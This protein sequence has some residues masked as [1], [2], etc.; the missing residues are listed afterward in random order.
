M[1]KDNRNT[2]QK[3]HV[4][5]ILAEG[6]IKACALHTELPREPCN[7]AALPFQLFVDALP[8]SQVV[9]GQFRSF[10]PV[11]MLDRMSYSGIG[12]GIIRFL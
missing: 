6:V 2:I 9:D 3:L 12:A 1:I 8:D 10:A 4:N 5:G 11:Q 7:G